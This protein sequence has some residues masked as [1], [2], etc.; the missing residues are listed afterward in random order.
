MKKFNHII[1]H[2]IAII[3]FLI[4]SYIYC[5]PLLEGKRLQ[6]GD[7]QQFKGMSKEV[8]DFRERTGNEALWTNRAFSGMPAFLIS[9]KSNANLVWFV[10]NL[11]KIGE[12]PGSYLFI[13]LLGFYIT[14]LAFGVNPW[15]SIPGA[16][17]FAFTSNI[18]ILMSAGHTSKT[19]AI[20][21]MPPI[22]AGVYMAYRRHMLIGGAITALFLGLQLFSFHPQ[23][24]YYTA[25]AIGL[26]ILF[27]FVKQNNEK[28]MAHFSRASAVLFIAAILAIGSNFG[29]LWRTYEYGEYSMR[30]GTELSRKKGKLGDKGLSKDYITQWSYGIDETLTFLIPNFKGGMSS[31]KEISENSTSFKM[32]K[33][34]PPQQANRY[35]NQIRAYHGSQPF[36]SG[37]IYLGAVVFFF[38]F[39]S[40]FI[41]RSKIKWWLLTI[42]IISVILSWGKNIMWL[43]SFMIDYF[44]GYG[45]FRDTKSILVIVQFAIPLLAM[46]GIREI[47]LG[48]VDK[49]KFKNAFKYS[50]YIIG[51]ITLLYTLLPGITDNFMSN[52]DNALPNELAR[53]L[54]NDR[55]MLLRADAFRS[56][57]FVILAAG[58]VWLSFK[59]KI[60]T[61]S[62]I[63]LLGVLFLVDMWP[64]NK[65]YLNDDNFG[66][67]K[68]IK[69]PFKLTRADRFILNDH[70][71]EFRVL[72]LTTRPF[73]SARASY[74]HNSIGG[75][76]GAKLQR[77][78]ELA[79]FYIFSNIENIIQVF[80]QGYTKEKMDNVLKQQNVLN[81]LNTKY[82]IIN[83]KSPPV[84]NQHRF[85]NAWFV[86][87]YQIVEGAD[88]EIN[89]LGNIQPDHSA[90]ID[91]KFQKHLK[92]IAFNKDTNA[93]IVLESYAPNQLI[94]TTRTNSKQLAVFSEIYYP[95]GWEAY[96]DD[97]PVPIL[98]ADYIL[99]CMVIPEGKHEI[100]FKFR[101]DS[102]YLGKKVSF[103]SS[104][105][106]VLLVAGIFIREFIFKTK[107]ENQE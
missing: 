13:C 51:G 60:K 88:E 29:K 41:V 76:H 57:I 55:K 68:E 74:F 37:P 52:S 23:I 102:Y 18:F 58:L 7:I 19:E 53:A 98:R 32:L 92:S 78:Q 49:E 48:R 70:A 11:L 81:M 75:Y 21:Y 99:R 82:I 73:N 101:P 79:D 5:S 3:F 90:V 105:I 28:N 59:Q 9:V 64:I 50:V 97:E 86:D 39:L 6:M 10:D 87:D 69:Q 36:T 34:M 8:Q 20:A 38:F 42:I 47:I 30:G 2:L 77:Y 61:N 12:R 83:P 80:R 54:R 25:I 95:E 106:L 15:L 84:L 22:I 17:A 1:P 45:K 46:L 44:P 91:K 96:I 40:L 24:T 107:Q 100:V 104:L 33:Q 62:T 56:F 72:D 65:R 26:F 43:T 27:E 71:E 67:K 93:S 85:G 4:V 14:L 31:P 16:I 63:V 35:V 66:P 94:Y 89:T 103:A